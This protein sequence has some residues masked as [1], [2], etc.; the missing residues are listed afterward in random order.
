MSELVDIVE[1]ISDYFVEGKEFDKE[2]YEKVISIV[3]KEDS[4]KDYV[5]NFYVIDSSNNND[6][7]L[8]KYCTGF[9][10]LFASGLYDSEDRALV[11]YPIMM[12]YN[13]H[14][15][16]KQM[17]FNSDEEKYMFENLLMLQTLL[18]ELEHV[19]Q[20]K[21]V[22]GDSDDLESKILRAVE[23]IKTPRTTSSY[24]Y[25]PTE[26]LAQVRSYT[27]MKEIVSL[28]PFDLDKTKGYFSKML[29]DE[30]SHGYDEEISST[31]KFFSILEASDKLDEVLGEHKVGNIK[32]SI[33]GLFKHLSGEYRLRRDSERVELGLPVSKEGLDAVIESK[34]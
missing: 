13:A 3:T 23:S 1:L 19:K 22:D 7:S 28:L 26:R 32:F 9:H 14:Q 4:T 10:S 12:K 2:F 11:L 16:S 6:P 33:S 25:D 20:H 24:D 30:L 5:L 31:K 21:L 18:H 34:V 15:I 17:E 29:R 8:E 27:K